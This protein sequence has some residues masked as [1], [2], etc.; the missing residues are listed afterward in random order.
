MKSATEL[1]IIYRIGEI[2]GLTLII[3]GINYLLKKLNSELFDVN[4]F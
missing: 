4:F 1:L 3:A 2:I